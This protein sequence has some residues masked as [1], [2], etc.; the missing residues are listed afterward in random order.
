MHIL[1][2]PDKFKHALH[3]LDA[4][5]AMHEGVLSIIPDATCELAPLADGGEGTLEALANLF[6]DIREVRVQNALG[7]DVSAQFAL[8][9]D[10]QSA[11]IETAQANG[12]WR[13]APTEYDPINASTYGVGQLILAA[14]KAGAKRIYLGLG[15][16]ATHDGGVGMAEALATKQAEVAQLDFIALCDV[17]SNLEDA[18]TFASQK[19]AKPDDLPVLKQRLSELAKRHTSVNPES[20]Y[21]GAG[22]GLG[23]GC[24]AFLNARLT[25]GAHGILSLLDTQAKIENADLV[26]TGEGS[27]DAQ[28]ASGKLIDELASQCKNADKPLYV[29]AGKVDKHIKIDGVTSTFNINENSQANLS[30]TKARLTIATAN[31][32][33]Y[34]FC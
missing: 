9:S 19:G 1:I 17:R 30:Q 33:K 22:G 25:S 16:S 3:A 27:F 7:R 28:T 15:G 12:L 4:A 24:A 20:R 26:L 29:L 14:L 18:I 21:T 31:A 10:G 23:F 6:P 5:K 8:S 34:F 32:L 11:L 13:L 2:A